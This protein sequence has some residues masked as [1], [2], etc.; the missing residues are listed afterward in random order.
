[1]PT[2]SNERIAGM[3]STHRGAIRFLGVFLGLFSIFFVFYTVRLL[4]VTNGLTAIRSGG[5]G[6][7]I[8]A[9]AFPILALSFGFGSWRCFA[10]TRQTNSGDSQ[11]ETS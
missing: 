9:I 11:K 6:A 3:A 5:N 2:S 8:G 10:K 1:M 7:Y 4:Y